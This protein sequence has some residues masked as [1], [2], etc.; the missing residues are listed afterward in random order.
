MEGCLTQGLVALTGLRTLGFEKGR[1]AGA[2]SA[3]GQAQGCNPEALQGRPVERP[4]S[5]AQP[6]YPA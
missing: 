6:F 2:C 4:F 3:V 1:P 5:P